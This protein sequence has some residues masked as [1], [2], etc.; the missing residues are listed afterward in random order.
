MKNILKILGISAALICASLAANGQNDPLQQSKAQP[1]A[2]D[3][4]KPTI[5]MVAN[6]H[7]DTQWNW[8]IQR[9]I[10][11]FLP[12][13]LKQNFALMEQY[14]DYIF[15]LE[16][17]VKYDMAKEY[18]PELYDQ[19][20]KY[21]KEGR[22][23]V[24]GSGW[25]ANDPNMPSVESNIRNYLYG[26]TFYKNEFG[27]KS[28]DVMLPDCFGFNYL[29]PTVAN[30]CGIIGFGTQ[31]LGWRYKP[32]YD[33]GRKVPF[34]FGIWEGLD[35]SRI[36]AAMDGGGYGWVPKTMA[37]VV[38][39]KEQKERMAEAQ[40][41][42][43][44]RYFGT[45]SSGRH[46]DQGGSPTPLSVDLIHNAAD[47]G[48][49]YNVKFASSDQMYLDYYMDPRLKTFKGELLMDVHATGCYTSHTEIKK[50]NREI[51]GLLG[52][53]EAL[54]VLAEQMG[55]M[56]YPSY[57]LDQIWKRTLV[58][59][60]HDDLT[61]T[62]IPGAYINTYNDHYLSVNQLEAL[63]E[64]QIQAVG[65]TLST[66][67]SGT[68]LLVYNPVSVTNR[69]VVTA[70]VP[71][72]Q[73]Y[74]SVAVFD[75]SGRRIKAQ[76][77]SRDADKARIA[78]SAALPSLSVS[79]FEVRPS[80]SGASALKVGKDYIENGVYKV[81]VNA[82]GDICSIVD[83]RCG[84]EM[85]K[86]GEAFGLR[87]FGNN[88]SNSWPAW[89]IMRSVMEQEPSK[90]N[91]DVKISCE[92]CGPLKAALK[93]EKKYGES[94][95]IQRIVLTNGAVDERIDIE[96]EIDWQ[97]RSSLLK[98]SFPVAFKC[99]EAEYDLGLGSIRRGNNSDIAYEVPAQKWADITADDASYGVTVMNDSKY[100][101]DKPDD[102]TLRLTLLHT[103]A[104]EKNYSHQNSM[105]LGK[106]SF[107]Y[108]I[109]GH[110]GALNT[111]EA[112]I[113][114]D[115]M[116][117]PCFATVAENAHGGSGRMV[118]LLSS[119]NPAIR[120]KAVKKAIDGDGYIVRTYEQSGKGGKA[121]LSFSTQIKDAYAANGIEENQGAAAFNGKA[122]NVDAK[123]YGLNTYRVQLACREAKA[124]RYEALQLPY[125]TVGISSDAFSAFGHMD[126]E[127]NSFAAEILP[128][129]LNVCGVPH[130]FA[131]ADFDNVVKCKGQKLELPEGTKTVHL[132]VASS[133]GEKSAC[134][135]A[136][137]KCTVP[138][139]YYSGIYGQY[140]WQGYYDS[141]LREGNVAYVGTHRHNGYKR[142][143]PYVLTYMFMVEIPVGEGCRTLLLPEDQDIVIFSATAE[144]F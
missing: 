87:I 50:L 91:G 113:Q 134:F 98:A 127:W 111:V 144:K 121:V 45:K 6:A 117:Q 115:I 80:S 74:G 7:W 128:S 92:Y 29:I 11:E 94:S 129:H 69:N 3:G 4:S 135:D 102:N 136:G 22:W 19:L 47:N 40:I 107:T 39:N 143:Q 70:I 120:I 54:G 123:P 78:F 90:V 95:F 28:T 112:D 26:Q 76:I 126:K 61:G 5:Y 79:V 82:D 109:I 141:F 27:V 101:W 48:E 140:G 86:A 31:K 55:V 1:A 24:S 2:A 51:E 42:A 131:K 49:L 9:S 38:D 93:I 46:G 77:V 100:G 41:P 21:V 18:M 44:Y 73:K 139:G 97:S 125:N 124:D 59:Q 71:L 30:H 32:F 58:H 130:S 17:A 62:S 65:A 8:D 110:K 89:E 142:N 16:G 72:A 25:D 119:G 75:A 106:H 52:A 104:T 56:E 108:S 35:G 13:T 12:N 133:N 68:P 34:N 14:P 66:K 138:V 63:I 88:Q 122:L 96:N 85:V 67:M 20:V 132:L 33:N 36:M 64:H 53:A 137:S 116:N 15:S 118:S 57:T 81:R 103:P 43:V 83:K 37:D 105:D 10:S 99:S 23:H 114:A 84:V 60:F